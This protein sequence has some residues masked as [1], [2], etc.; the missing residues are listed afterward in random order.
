MSGYFRYRVGGSV[1]GECVGR[2]VVV[3]KE[4]DGRC[5]VGGVLGRGFV[6]GR[7]VL[8]GRRLGGRV[9]F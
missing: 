7:S 6:D 9:D 1:F 4:L 8:R 5:F 2:R 3:Y